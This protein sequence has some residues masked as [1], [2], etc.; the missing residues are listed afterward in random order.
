LRGEFRE[1]D[2]NTFRAL[3]AVLS[4]DR[5]YDARLTPQR[6]SYLDGPEDSLTVVRCSVATTIGMVV[7]GE[8]DQD[9]GQVA[10]LLKILDDLQATVFALPWKVAPTPSP[11]P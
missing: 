11:S 4:R 6:P 8:I 7:G 9:N 2:P 3:Q 10:A 5:F 1:N